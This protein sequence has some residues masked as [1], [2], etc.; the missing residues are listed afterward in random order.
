MK[1]IKLTQ[2][3]YAKVDDEDFEWLNQFKW[4][5]SSKK[6]KLNYF[7]AVTN[8]SIGGKGKQLSMSRLIMGEPNNLMVDHVNHNSLD[9]RRSNLRICSRG[10]NNRNQR[11]TKGQSRFKGVVWYKPLNKW[12]AQLTKQG[13]CHYLGY[14]SLEK[15]AALAY[16][17]K[18]LEL[19]GEFAHLNKV[20]ERGY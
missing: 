5:A 11:K 15:E 16:N 4:C 9:N 17:L 12:K 1:L 14:F 2:G 13:K 19:F 18:A 3:K 8:I 6:K 10:E 7:M 20:R